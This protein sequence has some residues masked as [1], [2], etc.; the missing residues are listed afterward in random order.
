[1]ELV[2]AARTDPNL[3]PGSWSSGTST[4]KIPPLS[5]TGILSAKNITLYLDF[6]W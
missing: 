6:S 1:M 3:M 4:D 5:S 2:I